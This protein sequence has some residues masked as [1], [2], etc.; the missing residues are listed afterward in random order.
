M[1]LAG[2]KNPASLKEAATSP[3]AMRIRPLQP[4]LQR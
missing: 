1:L 2:G 3:Y 4:R